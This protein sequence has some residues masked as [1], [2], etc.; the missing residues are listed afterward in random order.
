MSK[1]AARGDASHSTLSTAL[2]QLGKSAD[3]YKMRLLSA[4]D[5][6]VHCFY[7]SYGFLA[8]AESS[9]RHI[10]RHDPMVCPLQGG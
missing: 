4:D 10:G 1:S 5:E 7:E 6:Y 8:R 2:V 3:C 9:R